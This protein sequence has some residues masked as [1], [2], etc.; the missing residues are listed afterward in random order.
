MILWYAGVC[1]KCEGTAVGKMEKGEDM[2]DRGITIV[3]LIVSIAVVGILMGLSYISFDD[4]VT[5]YKVEKA[6]REFYAD[7]MEARI[8]AMA[9]CRDHFIVM[10]PDRYTLYEDRN[11]NGGPDADEAMPTYPKKVEYRLRWNGI[12][13]QFGFSGRGM[14]TS[15]KTVWFETSTQPEYDCMRVSM[16]RII[17]GKMKYDEGGEADEC[18]VY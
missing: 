12:G 10:E 2:K 14:V 17:L 18:I 4:W 1:P 13:A 15:S 7:M 16:T 3:E 8:T 11:E 6:T 5:R 9:K